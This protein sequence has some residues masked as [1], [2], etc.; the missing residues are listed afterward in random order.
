MGTHV[1]AGVGGHGRA[2]ALQRDGQELCRLAACSLCCYDVTAQTIDCT[3]QH[4]G[5]DGRDA[6]LQTHGDA[7]AAQLDTVLS[8]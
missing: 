2:N 8:A 7:H 1:L 3:L 6:A 4:N 5:T